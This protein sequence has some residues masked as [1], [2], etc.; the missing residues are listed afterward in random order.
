MT[1]LERLLAATPLT[2]AHQPIPPGSEEDSGGGRAGQRRAGCAPAYELGLLVVVW[3]GLLSV[4]VLRGRKGAP[5][6]LGLTPCGVGYW[7]ITAAGFVWLFVTSVIGGRRLVRLGQQKRACDYLEGDVVWDGPRAA[8]CLVQALLAGVMAGLVGVGGGMVLGPMMLE[9]GVLPQVSSA[10][11]GTMVLLTSS[12]AA[13]V[14]LL[15]NL[16]PLDY[17]LGFGLVACAG[18]FVGKAG[19]GYLV[20]KYKLSALIIL[21]LGGLIAVSM[22]ATAAA[23]LLDLYS[24]YEAGRLHTAL[25]LKMPCS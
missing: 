2:N 25:L 18:G 8:R 12:S 6:L 22:L 5:G 1:P 13:A 11:T 16:I 14:F 20:K 7:G 4:L 9:L 19:L 24:K 15:A 21:L 17:A 10:T 3:I 23:G